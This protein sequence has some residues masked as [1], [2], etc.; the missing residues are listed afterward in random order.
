MALFTKEIHS[1]VVIKSSSKK[2]WEILKKFDK[3]KNWNPFMKFLE[4]KLVDDGNLVV[5]MKPPGMRGVTIKPKIFLV[6]EG[7]SFAWRG[8][9]FMK[10]LFDA[11]HYFSIEHLNNREVVF[12]QK[13]IFK[14]FLVP[15]FN[16]VIENTRIGFEEMNRELRKKAEK[17]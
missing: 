6:D 1:Q 9:M 16:G 7:K 12:T 17:K 2:V 4:G 13:E 14:G 11:T 5:Y 3:Y 15:M 10:G 8:K